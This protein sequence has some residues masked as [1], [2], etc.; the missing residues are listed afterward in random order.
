M[1][2]S[3]ILALAL[4]LACQT[5]L[6]AKPPRPADYG[7]EPAEAASVPREV[8]A[9]PSPERN[10]DGTYTVKLPLTSLAPVSPTTLRGTTG[11]YSFTL[12]IPERWEVKNASLSFGYVNSSSLVARLSRLSFLVGGKVLGQIE[13]RPE[14]PRGKVEIPIPGAQLTPGYNECTFSVAQSYTEEFCQDSSHP[15]LWTSLELDTASVEITYALKPVPQKLSALSGYLFDPR[16]FLGGEVNIV[17]PEF[18]EDTVRLAI[19]AAS[20]VALRLDYQA[21]RLSVGQELKPGVDNIVIGDAPFVKKLL[22]ARAPKIGDS[23]LALIPGEVYDKPGLPDLQTAVIVLS[24]MAGGVE[25]AVRAFSY[26]T[27]PFPDEPAAELGQVTDPDVATLESGKSL[28]R[29]KEYTLRSL[30]Y[31]TRTVRGGGLGRPSS[32]STSSPPDWISIR[33]ATSLS[34]CT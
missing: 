19:L 1:T 28:S 8:S 34:P 18:S 7:P 9:M 17:L 2:R 14:S 26:L 27:Y 31:V 12:P 4:L 24:G 22:G 13:L 23:T 20:G 10:P 29:D 30:G 33:T 6:A 11:A 3:A 32:C 15:S 16:C 5:A 21:V 25:K